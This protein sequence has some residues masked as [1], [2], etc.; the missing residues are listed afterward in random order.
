[1]SW[2]GES[3]DGIT[4]LCGIFCEHENNV[5][6]LLSLFWMSCFFFHSASAPVSPFKSSYRISF[7][8]VIILTE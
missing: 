3:I 5:A 6:S 2:Y 4:I 7:I 8:I 1:M